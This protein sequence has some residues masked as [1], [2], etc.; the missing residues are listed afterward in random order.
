MMRRLL[1]SIYNGN[2]NG[3]SV[4]VEDLN[5]SEN[6]SHSNISNETPNKRRSSLLGRFSRTP[7]RADLNVSQ[8][9]DES[10]VSL[11][12]AANS[13]ADTIQEIISDTSHLTGDNL[14]GYILLIEV[15]EGHKCFPPGNANPNLAAIHILLNNINHPKFV[16]ICYQVNIATGLFQALR[17]LRMFEMKHNKQFE[18]LLQ[19]YQNGS[20]N[21]IN[22]PASSILSMDI[23]SNQGVTFVA[24]KNISVLLQSL[25]SDP[26]T[27][28]QIRPL[29]TKI[30]TFP[31]GLLPITG[32][33]MQF[34]VAQ[35]ISIICKT[36]FTSQQIW[37]LHDIQ[38]M[39]HMIRQLYELTSVSTNMSSNTTTNNLEHSPTSRHHMETLLP[40]EKFAT[41]LKGMEA[42]KEGL[43]NVALKVL[44]DLIGS[45]I[46]ISTVLYHDFETVGGLKLLI[47][48]LCHTT[49]EHFLNTLNIITVLFFDSSRQEESTLTFASIVSTVLE[50]LVT[51]ILKLERPIYAN[52]SLETLIFFCK[53]IL[54]H[55]ALTAQLLTLTNNA[56]LHSQVPISREYVI[57]GMCYSLLT[58]YSNDS[59]KSSTLE[60]SY[61][62]LPT[63]ILSLPALILS[64]SFSAIL[65][66]INYICQCG[67][68]E[69]IARMPLLSL[70][71][72][73][74]TIVHQALDVSLPQP[75]R[76]LA[77]HKLE[78]C[79]TSMDAINKTNP[80]YAMEMLR[81]GFLKT[82]AFEPFELLVA[83]IS[84]YSS[85][86][87]S[88]VDEILQT[89]VM[90]VS[91]LPNVGLDEVSLQTYEK[92]INLLVDFNQKSPYAAEEIRKSGIHSLLR[93]ILG[94]KIITGNFVSSMLKLSEELSKVDTVNLQECIVAILALTRVVSAT[95]PPDYVKQSYFFLSLWKVLLENEQSCLL[96]LE[97]GGIEVV[98]EILEA[99]KCVFAFDDENRCNIGHYEIIR[100]LESILRY[101]SLLVF[102][103]HLRNE[104]PLS[105]FHWQFTHLLINTQIFEN[106]TLRNL[107]I[108]LI[109]S[110]ITLFS[111]EEQ[112]FNPFGLEIIS[113]LFCFV[114]L[115]CSTALLNRIFKYLEYTDIV[116]REN[117]VYSINRKKCLQF[118]QSESMLSL[119]KYITRFR[120]YQ[121]PASNDAQIDS[122]SESVFK[123]LLHLLSIIYQE[124]PTIELFLLVVKYGLQPTIDYEKC[125]SL[126]G[127]IKFAADTLSASSHKY[128]SRY[129]AHDDGSP[130]MLQTLFPQICA[131]VGLHG[132]E[133][134]PLFPLNISTFPDSFLSNTGFGE[135]P[136]FHIPIV[137]GF[138]MEDENTNEEQ[139][140]GLASSLAIFFSESTVSLPQSTVSMS[141]W[142]K[143]EKQTSVNDKLSIV[144]PTSIT[145][146]ES[147]SSGD[148]THPNRDGLKSFS[149][150][151]LELGIDEVTISVDIDVQ[152]HEIS[153]L[154]TSTFTTSN[155][156]NS[157]RKSEAI[158]FKPILLPNYYDGWCH[159]V[160]VIKRMKRFLSSANTTQCSVYM[161]GAQWVVNNVTATNNQLTGGHGGISERRGSASGINNS[162]EVDCLT[163]VQNSELR[164]GYSPYSAVPDDG[165]KSSF[166]I[167][168]K[169]ASVAVFPDILSAKQIVLM[170]LKGPLY[171]GFHQA[172]NMLTDSLITLSS[173]SLRAANALAKNALNYLAKTS[174][175]GLEFVVEPKLESHNDIVNAFDIPAF[176]PPIAVISATCSMIS[177]QSFV[178]STP[179]QVEKSTYIEISETKT[180]ELDSA[181]YSSYCT[182]LLPTRYS[183]FNVTNLDSCST[184]ATLKANS[185]ILHPTYSFGHCLACI[186]GPSSLL[187]LL[188]QVNSINSLQSFLT[189][190]NLSLRSSLYN[191]KV[192]QNSTIKIF[193]F[194][195]MYL[196]RSLLTPLALHSLLQLVL[197]VSVSSTSLAS[198]CPATTESWL[199]VDC[200]GMS[201]LISNHLLWDFE[202]NFETLMMLLKTWKLLLVDEKFAV[203]NAMRLS[204]LGLTRWILCL[205]VQ[206]V[207]NQCFQRYNDSKSPEAGRGHPHNSRPNSSYW[208]YLPRTALEMADYRD[209]PDE[210]LQTVMVVVRILMASELRYKDMELL[211]N[212]IQYTFN[213]P[214][215]NPSTLLSEIY[216][217]HRTTAI[218]TNSPPSTE[219][220]AHPFCSYDK[221][222]SDASF[223]RRRELT[224]ME[225]LRV[226]LIRLVINILDDN[227]EEMKSQQSQSNSNTQTSTRRQSS[228]TMMSSLNPVLN[229][230]SPNGFTANTNNI[231]NSTANNATNAA[232]GNIP[233]ISQGNDI[234]FEKFEVFREKCSMAWL[235]SIFER[236]CEAEDVATK[237]YMMRLIGIL[238]QQDVTMYR[239]FQV[240][241][242]CQF[243]YNYLTL[244]PQ[245]ISILLPLV[246]LVFRL[247]MSLLLYPI[248]IQADLWKLLQLFE[249]DECNDM[250]SF[251]CG[252]FYSSNG[253]IAGSVIAS[254]NNP[255]IADFSL[256]I[257]H[258]FFECLI[259]LIRCDRNEIS[260]AEIGIHLLLGT[261]EHSIEKLSYF[262]ALMQHKL[263]IEMHMTAYLACTGAYVEDGPQIYGYTAD[264]RDLNLTAMV[265]DDYF[266]WSEKLPL[267]QSLRYVAKETQ[268]NDDSRLDLVVSSELASI[269][270]RI[271]NLSIKVL[272][273]GMMKDY[274]NAKV[275]QYFLISFPSETSFS[276]C[277]TT[278]S[279][280]IVSK[281]EYGY[282]LYVME[283]IEKVIY[284]FT[285]ENH[286]DSKGQTFQ[287][288]ESLP[289]FMS[290]TR[291]LTNLVH[292]M[293]G[294]FLYDESLIKLL[295]LSFYLLE[296][297]SIL[298][299]N[300]VHESNANGAEQ[301]LHIFRELVQNAR[302]LSLL[303]LLFVQQCSVNSN[304]KM[305]QLTKLPILSLIRSNLH[306][307]FP[308]KE[309]IIDDNLDAYLGFFNSYSSSA[310]SY[311]NTLGQRF[312][313]PHQSS[314]NFMPMMES[315][316]SPTSLLGS[317]QPG[318]DYSSNS[319]SVSRLEDRSLSS[320]LSNSNANSAVGLSQSSNTMPISSVSQRKTPN[321]NAITQLRN[322][323][324][325][326]NS[327]FLIFLVW[328]CSQWILEEDKALRMEGIRI[329]AYLARN[330]RVLSDQL[331]GNAT[332]QMIHKVLSSWWNN[333]GNNEGDFDSSVDLFRD[334]FSRLIPNKAGKYEI[335]LGNSSPSG[336]D[337]MS[338][339]LEENRYAD[340]A[341]WISF[342]QSKF[343]KFL[344]NIDTA[345]G[346][347]L[348]NL[349][350]ED[351]ELQKFLTTQ[352]RAKDLW[353]ISTHSEMARLSQ[354]R[355]DSAQRLGEK[356]IKDLT[357]WKYQGIKELTSGMAAWQKMRSLVLCN[358]I[359]GKD[360]TAINTVSQSNEMGQSINFNIYNQVIWRV[361]FATLTPE[362]T[363]KK[364]VQDLSPIYPALFGIIPTK[365]PCAKFPSSDPIYDF[366][367]P[368]LG[369]TNDN[370]E[371]DKDAE[372]NVEELLRSMNAK[373]I[374]RSQLSMESS[375]IVESEVSDAEINFLADDD[376]LI[377]TI[378]GN[379]VNTEVS[380]SS[381]I[382]NTLP[383]EGSSEGL[384]L[385]SLANHS[386]EDEEDD[387]QE[388]D[389]ILSD[390][391]I[392]TPNSPVQK[393]SKTPKS[394]VRFREQVSP[395][396]AV[397]NNTEENLTKSMRLPF[398]TNP[399]TTQNQFYSKQ[400]VRSQKLR[401]II[402]GMINVNELKNCKVY[403]I[404]RIIGL[405][406]QPGI[407]FFTD[408][409]I[410]IING[411]Q[412]VDTSRKLSELIFTWIAP[413]TPN[414][415]FVTESC[416]HSQD[417]IINISEIDNENDDDESW[418]KSI[419]K[420][421][422][423]SYQVYMKITIDEIYSFFKRR[424]ELKYTALEIVDTHGLTVLFSC[425]TKQECDFILAVLLE[426][427]LPA[428]IFNKMIGLKNLQ[429]LRGV[430]NMYARLIS[431][432][433]T[434]LTQLW[435][436]FEIT[437]FEYLMYI[438]SC[439]GRSCV[440]LTQ[441]PVFPWVL[442]DFTSDELDLEDPAIYR[443]FKK[444]MGALGEK[445]AAQYYDRYI[446]MQ[447][448]YRDSI[449]QDLSFENEEAVND[450]TLNNVD[451]ENSTTPKNNSP[452]T[453]PPFFYGT[454]YSCAGYVLHYLVRLQ[455]YTNMSL[456]LQGGHFDK[457][458]RLFYHVE[459]SWKS[460]SQDNLQDVRE[461]IPEFFYLPDFLVNKNAFR[462]GL[463]QRGHAVSDVVLPPWSHGNAAEFI[464][465]HRAALESQYVSNNLPSWI[466][467]IFGYKQRGR[468]AIEAKNVFLHITYE[469]EVD[470]EKMDDTVLR[471]AT[472]AQINNFGQTPSQLFPTKPHPKRNLPD[473]LKRND[474][475]NTN[476][477]RTS[478][479][480]LSTSVSV[481]SSITLTS[482]PEQTVVN[483]VNVT[484]EH[485]AIQYHAGLAP[486]LTVI[487]SNNHL[488][489]LNKLFYG[490]VPNYQITGKYL[491]V[492]DIR[493][494]KDNKL[495]ACSQGSLFLPPY[496]RN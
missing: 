107:G 17:L 1:T 385:E 158:I 434:A 117:T 8:Q 343:D 221:S 134:P 248:Q 271:S 113:I 30:F 379:V 135:V 180:L 79:F 40:G 446:T 50:F 206:I 72:A 54:R 416:N 144:V 250:F 387:G 364:L 235:F 133:T 141:C 102:H 94:E 413:L 461:L 242:G 222:P 229:N 295:S 424:Y 181:F 226:Y 427:D 14:Q 25:C 462:F 153:V 65:T 310:M 307:L 37:Y 336:D 170:F 83:K 124:S 62:F 18:K 38:M 463:T 29:L 355:A 432:F 183:I 225:F 227:T 311:T 430:H 96:Y 493:V 356:V 223:H 415:S 431:F 306:H 92:I 330:R 69:T 335:F 264:Y 319:I 386:F 232:S 393:K 167:I 321:M 45:T 270:K 55:S 63:L 80:R 182:K 178:Y 315:S 402:K 4:N 452:S 449:H 168:L 448:F 288:I 373:G 100:C 323:R 292:L 285:D 437:N 414:S 401:E 245:E 275:L 251:V 148:A 108:E 349:F 404:Q 284:Q 70:C 31:L 140:T 67:F 35:V 234:S 193:S 81:S 332:N 210:F 334:G 367:E 397:S 19:R 467:L 394:K 342:H 22:L 204:S 216:D 211:T 160:V 265:V 359:W 166:P 151:C 238:I 150:F 155:V 184:V 450:A 423:E 395:E 185:S 477:I 26:S 82:I 58:L 214:K 233:N 490:Q 444:P 174:L 145:D 339:E 318:S 314:N 146:C 341:Y 247:P 495:I 162:V 164:I 3:P 296:R 259:G 443:D 101:L 451:C 333:G 84:Q 118:N 64:E 159:C 33:H 475:N 154:F 209:I 97:E 9:V 274:E 279:S 421:C 249:L 464:R 389:S 388:A 375:N 426:K 420:Y 322:E 115:E 299:Q 308:K 459:N 105:T 383:K 351:E 470:V 287:L 156:S 435:Q 272:N 329:L 111:F 241:Q 409:S 36:G 460:A 131:V 6:I 454:H 458:D 478:D 411:I 218:L 257:L 439:A 199:L 447:E 316:S 73:V 75:I 110:Y 474:I 23:L 44:I 122:S 149:L 469:G 213:Y 237:A 372:T 76:L 43:W 290:V 294:N 281:Y 268:E 429:L 384:C 52:D 283:L 403:N 243:F 10:L 405:E 11:E 163:C 219:N 147:I 87:G 71:A 207:Q 99:M 28:E 7:N 20:A 419:W 486:P 129:I 376:N 236:S 244:Q 457:P 484:I 132:R 380:S 106:P 360:L 53:Q 57:Q 398:N 191:L 171:V 13:L 114:S 304:E 138:S 298:P 104:I 417:Q 456:A 422:L 289:V 345:L 391:Y 425:E 466:D 476:L 331:I 492:S 15:L 473:V 179:K 46:A 392:S 224:A 165:A 396:K 453:P 399:F 277:S 59:M 494:S 42:E 12:Q 215:G 482:S 378:I 47:H 382:L 358:P 481:S 56:Q 262:R 305:K 175:S 293:K 374:L 337:E 48:I 327:I 142:F 441:Y 371:A 136:S 324:N 455:P 280:C 119:C 357:M 472:L 407:L 266:S 137:H 120:F 309:S 390:S 471:T 433:L 255:F 51:E 91:A 436:H 440:D 258:I 320:S 406:A 139:E 348:P 352:L 60:E 228:S 173:Y 480:S 130:A 34:H 346:S 487:G 89:P 412:A 496:Y 121:N 354:L 74:T 369:S 261:A 312:Q 282:Q 230:N 326:V 377:N 196:P 86:N 489:L 98:M 483:N 468:S 24:S 27:I 260:W 93:R 220:T 240:L 365:M 66:T 212:I 239:D 172:N 361:D 176:N 368:Q 340:F 161:N 278:G 313:I 363:H 269:G 195:F 194:L 418:I 112:F 188:L 205:V 485:S 328:Y 128:S 325:K 202:N 68:D 41:V 125:Q 95:C 479:R 400:H 189:L 317:L 2:T 353:K 254:P 152:T 445:R 116:P 297:L 198:T 16:E 408:T 253:P 49:P 85:P 267:S 350:N 187:P 231:G 109:F 21:I 192:M 61:C 246:A 263:A 303:C 488:V 286:G 252:E 201:Y 169:I 177:Q 90:T 465:L 256:P 338:T 126:T 5:G 438:N 88:I 190:L 77:V 273:D 302:F 123:L 347:L 300:A 366:S 186:G 32:K 491:A 39:T 291:N 127:D 103:A 442:K 143:L 301:Y 410:H 362:L 203:V 276:T 217:E 78:L 200:V 208:E 344:R 370:Y 381:L 197:D 428:S 157:N